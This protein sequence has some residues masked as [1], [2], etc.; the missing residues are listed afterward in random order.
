MDA[1]YCSVWDF[2]YFASKNDYSVMM[3]PSDILCSFLLL[4]LGSSHGK[5]CN[6]HREK[7]GVAERF[8]EVIVSLNGGG[9]TSLHS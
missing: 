9:D 7:T 5:K 4:P 1:S 6:M 2:L 3:I 8:R